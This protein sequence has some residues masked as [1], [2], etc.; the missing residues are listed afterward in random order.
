MIS[1][2]EATR[3]IRM[4]ERLRNA[5]YH[6]MRKDG[7]HKSSEGAMSISFNLPPVVGDERDPYWSVEAY[8]YLLCTDGRSQTWIG[9][10]A[11]EAIGK[12][13]DAVANWCMSAEMEQFGQAMGL[14]PQDM[15]ETDESD[16]PS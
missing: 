3:F 13:E 5:T 8:S 6:E 12:A 15:G 11:G 10:S 14:D 4:Q 7:M 2:D 16:I 1:F 9:K